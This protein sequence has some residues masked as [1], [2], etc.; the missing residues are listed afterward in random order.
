[1]TEL[2]I[3]LA[4]GAVLAGL[5][6]PAIFDWYSCLKVESDTTA[7]Y[8][9]IRWAQSEAEKQG[10]LAVLGGKL[11]RRRI[12][13]AL[14][15]QK[16]QYSVWRW[17]DDNGNGV[18]EAGEFRPDF[19]AGSDGPIGRRNLEYATTGFVTQGEKAV[20]RRGCTGSP[21][22]PARAIF[23][24]VTC[25][26][27]LCPGCPCIRF[28]GHGFFEGMN[29]AAIYLTNG[30]YTTALNLNLAGTPSICRWD[31]ETGEWRPVR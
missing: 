6:A 24:P 3:V 20:T 23:G 27:S 9:D 26:E 30:K 25:P 15:E 29:N 28:N 17:Q 1:L 2:L 7:L 22:P 8:Q 5:A 10:D 4:I 13:I 21:G 31:G 16:R 12:Y 18:A 11:V 14:D 19:A